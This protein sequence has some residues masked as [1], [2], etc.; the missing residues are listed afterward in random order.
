MAGTTTS[1]RRGRGV[2]SETDASVLHDLIVQH[3]AAVDDLATVRGGVRAMH[4]H[5]V[6]PGSAGTDISA[7]SVFVASVA[8]TVLDSVKVICTEATVGVDGSNTLV[9][10]L[11]NITEGVDIATITR[12]ATNSANDVLSLTLTAANA[13]LAANDVLGITVTQGATADAGRLVFQWE[14]QTQASDAAADLT[15]AKIGDSAGVAITATGA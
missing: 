1:S 13:D 10:T 4:R 5:E 7:R 2:G 3:N 12:T 6:D 8:M 11:R 15:A 9:L 14:T